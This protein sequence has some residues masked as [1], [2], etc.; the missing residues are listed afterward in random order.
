MKMSP[1]PGALGVEKAR[2]IA[3]WLFMN[4]FFPDIKD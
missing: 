3:E 1:V 4:Y 2:L